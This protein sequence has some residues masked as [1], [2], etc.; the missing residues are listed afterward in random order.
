MG[1]LGPNGA[2]KTTLISI[3]PARGGLFPRLGAGEFY[4][5]HASGSLVEG[6]NVF[7]DDLKTPKYVVR[8]SLP[9]GIFS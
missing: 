2:G 8:P 6:L 9:A 7:S 1:L 4:N 5:L 3:L